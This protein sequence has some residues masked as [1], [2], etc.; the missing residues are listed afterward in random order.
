MLH[1]LKLLLYFLMS[2]FV[3][4][5]SFLV[6]RRRIEF[7]ERAGCCATLTRAFWSYGNRKHSLGPER[8]GAELAQLI[9]WQY[10]CSLQW[11]SPHG[12]VA[13][14][15]MRRS[16]EP[17]QRRLCPICPGSVQELRAVRPSVRPW[18]A[19]AAGS[20]WG[21]A[22]QR[23]G[24]SGQAAPGRQLQAGSEGPL[25]QL[26]PLGKGRRRMGRQ[27]K[28]GRVDRGWI[29]GGSRRGTDPVTQRRL[30]FS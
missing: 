2:E 23:A 16:A 15:Q 5:L 6:K 27:G 11:R 30:R 29:Q 10:R 13:S 17:K 14:L 22:G 7:C 12:E 18:C 24:S 25:A 3:P 4:L 1:Q 20:L 21:S 9:C 19:P 26:G 28:G 8:A